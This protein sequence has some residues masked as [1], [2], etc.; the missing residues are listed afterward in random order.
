MKLKK[1]ERNSFKTIILRFINMY[2]MNLQTNMTEKKISSK[3]FKIQ[4]PLM[5]IIYRVKHLLKE[6]VEL[7]EINISKIIMIDL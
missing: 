2:K 5:L 1:R 3:E 6:K 7:T 4:S